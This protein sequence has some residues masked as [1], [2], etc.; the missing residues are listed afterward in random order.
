MNTELQNSDLKNS[1]AANNPYQSYVGASNKHQDL[2]SFISR[3]LKIVL[4]HKWLFA[5]VFAFVMLLVLIYALK[6][7]KMYQSNYEVFYN[8]TM[9]E[10]MSMDN[11]PIVK[12]DFDK[13]YWLSAMRSNVVYRDWETDRKSTRLNSSHIT[14]SRMP[15]SA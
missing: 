3:F 12:S 14:R 11:A 6:Q 15:S 13:N 10:Y 7:P 9:R 4:I 2:N 5:A 1:E 8:E